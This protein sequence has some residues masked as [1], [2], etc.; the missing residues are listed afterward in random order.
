MCYT[1]QRANKKGADQTAQMYRLVLCMQQNQAVSQR[2]P[3]SILHSKILD[4]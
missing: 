3:N 4:P 2:G 1:F